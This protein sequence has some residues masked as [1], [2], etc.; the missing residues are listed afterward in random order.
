MCPFSE[1]VKQVMYNEEDP[2][3]F[4][5]WLCYFFCSLNLLTGSS[6]TLFKK[7]K[8]IGPVCPQLDLIVDQAG[9][10]FI[11]PPASAS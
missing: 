7:K 6:V 11:N 5:A 8:K 4:N 10:K 2:P 9:L 1:Q 3:G